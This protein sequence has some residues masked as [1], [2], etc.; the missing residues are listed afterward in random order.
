MLWFFRPRI[1]IQKPNGQKYYPKQVTASVTDA[2]PY[3]DAPYA[4]IELATNRS[5]ETAEYINPVEED[6]I[7]RV[8][9]SCRMSEKEKCV[10]VD[11]F[12]GR[13][14]SIDGEYNTKNNTTVSCRGH[15]DEA[16]KLLI[17]ESKTWTGTI[18]ARTILG[19]LV[20]PARH[21]SRLTWL[22]Q[23]PHVDQSGVV[24]FTDPE[25]AYATKADQTYLSS[26]F[27]DLEKESGSTW[28][29]GTKSTY[30]VGGSLDKTYLT[31]KKLDTT[32]TN[33]YKAI[34][35]TAR[36]LGSN[37]EISI[38]DQATQVKIKGDTPTSGTQYTGTAT[39]ATA[40]AR[41]GYKTDVDIYSQ[42][43]SNATC[44]SIAAGILPSKVSASISGTIKLVGT[45][46]AHPGDMVYVR[47]RSTELNGA[48]VAG[49]FN[50]YR[51]RHNITSSS[52]TTEIQVGGII[53]DAYDLIKNIKTIA[54]TTKCNQVK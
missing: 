13:V 12:E 26:V 45:P 29:I 50:V 48:I 53:T 4:Q 22:N 51:V 42:L 7:V 25:S 9:V 52:Y 34:Q 15:I 41:Y 2:Y 20:T 39:D 23:A 28:K 37:F 16:A 5:P 33:K 30:T 6:D 19:D 14:R 11:L 21:V 32:P 27:K 36:Y 1:S 35:G 38:E 49:N 17:D 44:A 24:S 31:W 10:F 46:E 43:Q 8:Q 40:V 54:V 18:E 47:S 3:S